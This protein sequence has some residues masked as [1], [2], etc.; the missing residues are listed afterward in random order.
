MSFRVDELK[1]SVVVGVSY[2]LYSSEVIGPTL[3]M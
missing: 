3:R 1:Y 2:V